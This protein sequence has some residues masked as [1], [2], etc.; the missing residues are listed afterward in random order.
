MKKLESP[1]KRNLN[2]DSVLSITNWRLTGD[3]V[4]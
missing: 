3:K 2:S 4:D 1:D